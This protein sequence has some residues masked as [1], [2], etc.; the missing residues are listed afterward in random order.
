M[1][2]VAGRL[3]IQAAATALQKPN[4]GRGKLMGGV[5]GVR[6]AD[7]VIIGAGIVGTNAAQVAL[8]MGA[9]VIFIDINLDRLRYLHEV[10][11]GRLTTL[12]SNPLNIAQ[13][14]QRADLLVGAEDGRFYLLERP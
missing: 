12:A 4:G 10:M 11:G 1:S 6:P 2:E 9:H 8:G 13:A 5:A 14:V 3:S 7:V